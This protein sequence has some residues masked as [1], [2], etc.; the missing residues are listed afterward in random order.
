MDRRPKEEFEWKIAAA[1]SPTKNSRNSNDGVRSSL[2]KDEDEELSVGPGMLEDMCLNTPMNKPAHSP[3]EK[4]RATEMKGPGWSSSRRTSGQRKP[5]KSYR[6]GAKVTVSPAKVSNYNTSPI[7]T[8]PILSDNKVLPRGKKTNHRTPERESLEKPDWSDVDDPVEVKYFSQDEG[9]VTKSQLKKNSSEYETSP[10]PNLAACFKHSN[11]CDDEIL[12]PCKPFSEIAMQLPCE[13]SKNQW[14]SSNQKLCESSSN[15]WNSAR[16]MPS[17]PFQNQRNNALQSPCGF[18]PRQLHSA[19]QKPGSSSNPWNTAVHSPLELSQCQWNSADRKC[20]E[21]SL[22]MCNTGND[23]SLS[24]EISK[25]SDVFATPGC[26]VKAQSSLLTY[27][28]PLRSPDLLS[29]GDELRSDSDCSPMHLRTSPSDRTRLVSV[30]APQ[31]MWDS[32]SGQK[33]RPLSFIDTH[34][35]LDMLYMKLGFRGTFA[36]FRRLYHSSFSSRFEGCI[37]DFCNPRLMVREQLWE[38]LLSEELVWGAFG[39]HPHFAKE[40]NIIHEHSILTA[41]RHPK[42]VA[43]GEIGLDYSSKCSTTVGQQKKVFERQ[44]HLAV[45]MK[46][47]L[48]IHCRDADEDLL[49]ILKRLVPRDYKIH[50]HCFTN[51]YD[52]IEPFLQEFPNMSVGFTALLTYPKA[53]KVKDAIR[54]IPLHRIVVETDAPYF[55]PYQVSKSVCRFSHPGMAIHTLQE[56]SHLKGELFSTVLSTL[57]QTTAKLY[58]L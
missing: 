38:P 30:E 14:N 18:I 23:M 27:S 44:L 36:H 55:L 22:V 5:R 43:F 8:E 42:A 17:K 16:E 32:D 40:Y 4:L 52:V 49:E 11:A 12:V 51:S 7:L 24:S 46:K 45:Q 47:P 35:H 41:M 28:F 54:R 2:W 21:S 3:L 58:D 37:A 31:S 50:R 26:T 10:L 53:V 25:R 19:F 33:A 29:S 6:T 57:R 39:C 20:R 15:Q 48:V 13:S 56:I 9:F 34:C 1:F